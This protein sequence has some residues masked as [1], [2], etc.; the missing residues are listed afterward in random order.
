MLMNSARGQPRLL[1]LMPSSKSRFQAMIVV[2]SQK[3]SRLACI[4]SA[5]SCRKIWEGVAFVIDP[6]LDSNY[7]S[8][9]FPAAPYACKKEHYFDV[10]SLMS[11][12]LTF[13]N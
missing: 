11:L 12:A 2:V 10:I 4:L 13:S 7:Q 9:C 1:S 6:A 8:V 5:Y 3:A